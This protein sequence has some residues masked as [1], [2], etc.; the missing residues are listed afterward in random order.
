MT[1]SGKSPKAHLLLLRCQ[2]LLPSPLDPS[3]DVAYQNAYALFHSGKY[4][5]AIK[6]ADKVLL[7][8]PQH[9]KA[10]NIKGI[11]LCFS[12]NFTDGMRNID[13]SLS[14]APGF[15]YARF[16]KA[17]AYSYNKRFDEALHWYDSALS[18]ENYVWSHYGKAAIYGQKNDVT[19]AVKNLKIAIEMD[20]GVKDVAK[21]EKDFN[22]VRNSKEF[23][24]LVQ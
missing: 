13:A 21:G 17:L 14:I 10:L 8:D 18:V 20:K 6:T 5:A 3:L 12:D 16:N 24:E 23:K 2:T 15:G 4:S 11:A 19:N 9:Y 7:K 22:P 1:R